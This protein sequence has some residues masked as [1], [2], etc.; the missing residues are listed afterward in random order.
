MEANH[1]TNAV[2]LSCELC[3]YKTFVKSSL[4]THINRVHDGV[5]RNECYFCASNHEVKLDKRDLSTYR[6]MRSLA[7]Q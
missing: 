3:E 4:T 2:P 1:S 5:K 7:V 6:I